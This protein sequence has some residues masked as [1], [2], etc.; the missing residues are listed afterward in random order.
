MAGKP[1]AK[2]KYKVVEST[3]VTIKYVYDPTGIKD[4]ELHDQV[5]KTEFY[6]ITGKQIAEP[7]S[8]LFIKKS[9]CLDGSVKTRKVVK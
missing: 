2:P 8:G 7:K 5:V 1:Q 3:T 9:F 4:A 6:D